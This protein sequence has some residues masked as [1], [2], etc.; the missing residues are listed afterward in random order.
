MHTLRN[1]IKCIIILVLIAAIVC[2]GWVLYPNLATADTEVMLIETGM[3]EPISEGA[4]T[5]RFPE[6]KLT[7]PE[8]IEV[9]SITVQFTSAI[10]STDAIT[11]T[12]KD[13]FALLA[14]SKQGNVSINADGKSASDWESFLRENL[15]ISLSGSG[16]I[17]KLRFSASA[18]KADNIYDYN[19]ENGHYYLAVNN[20]VPWTT[21]RDNAAAATYMG[22]KGYLATVTS[23]EENNYLYSMIQMNTWLGG[24]CQPSYLTGLDLNINGTPTTSLYGG[25]QA[26]YFW[27]TGPEAGQAFWEGSFG[28][29]GTSHMYTH[30]S[31]EGHYEPNNAGSGEHC[32]HMWG[33][34]TADAVLGAWNDYA[35]TTSCAYIIEFGDMPDDEP[36]TDIIGVEASVV[37]I[38]LD[39][40]GKTLTTK[41]EDIEAGEPIDVKTTINGKPV[42][43]EYTYYEK[44][45][46][47]TWEKIDEVP[48]HP[49]EYKVV[50]SIPDH[51]DGE[52]KFKIVS[53]K[54]DISKEAEYVK[55][56]D[57]KTEYTE[58]IELSNLGDV[59]LEYD[60]AE[61]NSKN[62]KE[63]KTITL[64]GVRLTGKDSI[65]YEVIGIVDGNIEV[66]G[67]IVPRPLHISPSFA[68]RESFVGIALPYEYSNDASEYI[69]DSSV[70]RSISRMVSKASERA[71]L[72]SMLAYGDKLLDTLG[73]PVYTC[74]MSDKEL[75]RENPEE[76]IYTLS[77]SFP[78]MSEE[79]KSNYDITYDTWEVKIISK[80]APEVT[81]SPKEP[82]PKEPPKVIS[83][84]EDADGTS[85]AVVR[86]RVEVKQEEKVLTREEIEEWIHDRYVITP[87]KSEGSLTYSEVKI[88]RDGKETGEIDLSKAGTYIVKVT[89]TDEV[90]NSTELVIEYV[91]GADTVVMTDI[92]KTDDTMMASMRI[93]ALVMIIMALCMIFLTGKHI[94]QKR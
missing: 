85:H 55:V 88:E 76:G 78:N 15:N 63:A 3:A 80:R 14:G 30:W 26:R 66:P 2:T 41:A 50:S 16:A 17:K 9:K 47:G 10:E 73:E 56:Y 34:K 62:V 12:E 48:K 11:V 7:V 28:T 87:A 38:N 84:T 86:D 31:D 60:K 33:V 37:E 65:D 70:G 25:G 42:D 6:L 67:K 20:P 77:V 90:G 53:K 93:S 61:F 8:G 29:A 89:V 52:D 81:L 36:I 1:N 68:V 5:Y 24:T 79:A 92:P 46:D 18:K 35:G 71:K 58:E 23:E 40:T 83:V 27:A 57:G 54:I 94:V 49:G 44:K 91:V 19:A 75:N 51:N 4:T 69:G 32:T 21:A 59:R 72:Q 82:T 45:P 39:P 64:N 22:M 43:P 13:G 74:V